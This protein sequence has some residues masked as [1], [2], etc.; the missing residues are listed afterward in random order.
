MRIMLV[1]DERLARAELRRLL[2]PYAVEIVAEAADGLSALQAYAQARPDVLFLDI[3]MP[4]MSGIE[5]ACALDGQAHIVFC[6]AY[7]EFASKAFD[8]QAAD[9]L[10]KPVE[11][12][13]LAQTMARLQA[14]ASSYLPDEHR[15][16]LR[17][18]DQL[19]LL[20]LGDV[21]R[22][23]SAGNYVQLT[24]ASGRYLLAGSL[25]RLLPRLDPQ[26]FLLASRGTVCRFDAIT[27]LSDEG[28]SALSLHLSN[29]EQ[30]ALS[31]RQAKVLRERF[32]L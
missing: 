26:R 12:A 27:S 17:R 20:R 24:S 4:G 9:Y 6:T 10:V 2:A 18:G 8:L 3:D 25:A 23:D 21:L 14:G 7:A 13:R 16:L 11:P 28:G 15:L 31:R 29:G 22:F 5:L 1:D 30:I 19:H 32:T